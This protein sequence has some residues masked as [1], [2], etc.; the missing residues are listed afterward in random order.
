MG[1]D[2]HRLPNVSRGHIV[3]QD[4]FGTALES[5]P[6][7]RQRPHFD[8]DRLIAAPVPD[9]AIQCIRRA[10][11]QRDMVVLD[12]YAVGKI[13]S[14]ILSSAATYSILVNHPKSRHR[15]AS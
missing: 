3:K 1:T 7:V 11:R 10:S 12:Q 13:Q 15:F 9:G 14:V 4:G 6:H 5:K 8:F 2:F